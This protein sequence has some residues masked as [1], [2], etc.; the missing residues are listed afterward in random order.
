MNERFLG[1]CVAEQDHI[2]IGKNWGEKAG[3]FFF[4]YNRTQYNACKLEDLL[5]ISIGCFSHEIRDT[6]K[7][8]RTSTFSPSSIWLKKIATVHHERNRYPNSM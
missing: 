6:W 3:K 1:N 8:K 5:F 4:L 2:H 7:G